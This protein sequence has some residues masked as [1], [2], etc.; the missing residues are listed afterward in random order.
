MI[1]TLIVAKASFRSKLISRCFQYRDPGSLM[2]AFITFVR[3]ISDDTNFL[4]GFGRAP[5]DL[6]QCVL[7][8]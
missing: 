1:L 3:T 6:Q 2:H 5:S 8:N 4:H 7:Y